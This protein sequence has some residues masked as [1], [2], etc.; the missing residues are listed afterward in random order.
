MKVEHAAGV[1]LGKNLGNHKQPCT[2]QPYYGIQALP[3][4]DITVFFFLKE[5]TSGVKQSQSTTY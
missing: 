2:S 4:K 1:N 5:K 3:S